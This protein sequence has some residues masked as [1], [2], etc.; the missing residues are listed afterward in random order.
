MPDAEEEGVTEEVRERITEQN[1]EIEKSNELFAKLKQYVMIEPPMDAEERKDY[2]ENANEKCLV[3]VMNYREPVNPDV[4][5]EGAPAQ[6][7]STLSKD[8]H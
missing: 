7:A 4:S 3:K 1:E 5:G 2:Y 6:N 8:H